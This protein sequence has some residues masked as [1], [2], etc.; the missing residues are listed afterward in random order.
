MPVTFKF[1]RQGDSVVEADGWRTSFQFE[2]TRADGEQYR[3]SADCRINIEQRRGAAVV[4]T[5]GENARKSI[6]FAW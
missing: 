1:R 6:R 3:H 4:T 5:V 2:T